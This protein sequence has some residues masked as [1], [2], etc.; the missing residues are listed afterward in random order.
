MADSTKFGTVLERKDMGDGTEIVLVDRGEEHFGRYATWVRSLDD[1]NTYHGNY[2]NHVTE[3]GVNFTH[4]S[5]R[6]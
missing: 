2:Y 4:R 6:V 3:A 1:G 5:R